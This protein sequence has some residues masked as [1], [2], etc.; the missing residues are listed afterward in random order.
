MKKDHRRKTR[1]TGAIMLGATL[2][3]GILLGHTIGPSVAGLNWEDENGW[4][5]RT[6]FCPVWFA[7]AWPIFIITIPV[8]IVSAILVFIAI[9]K[10]KLCWLSIFGFFLIDIYWLL[11]VYVANIVPLD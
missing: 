10:E 8:V 6:T 9:K 2:V 1:I 5:W 11:L 3:A 4:L 7:S